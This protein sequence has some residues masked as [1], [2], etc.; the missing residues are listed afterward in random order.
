MDHSRKMA[1]VPHDMLRQL[2]SKQQQLDNS[3]SNLN[4]S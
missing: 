2:Q 4:R 1:L 3:D